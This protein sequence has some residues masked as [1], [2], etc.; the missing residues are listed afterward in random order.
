MKGLSY[1]AMGQYYDAIKSNTK[2]MISHIGPVNSNEFDRVKY[3]RGKKNSYLKYSD[4]VYFYQYQTDNQSYLS[5]VV[6]N[7]IES[8]IRGKQGCH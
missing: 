1:A 7:I 3:I 5:S 2:L 6:M 4:N 8:S